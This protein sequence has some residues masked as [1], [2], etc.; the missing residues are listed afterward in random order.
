MVYN[1][2]AIK[3][4][5]SNIGVTQVSKPDTWPITTPIYKSAPQI[6]YIHTIFLLTN[7]CTL[8]QW[9]HLVT[10]H[11]TAYWVTFSVV[12]RV[13][14]THAVGTPE[15][16]RAAGLF[17]VIFHPLSLKYSAWCSLMLLITGV[18]GCLILYH[19]IRAHIVESV[20]LKKNLC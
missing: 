9:R 8:F 13:S 6:M 16:S 3:D 14:Q 17:K 4:N 18:G 1:R 2:C 20:S 15:E 12:W 10:W 5:I 11:A 19:D 7:H